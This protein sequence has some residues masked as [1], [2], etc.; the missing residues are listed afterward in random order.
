MK[1]CLVLLV[2][3]LA[4]IPSP[5]FAQLVN[6]GSI[7]VNSSANPGEVG[8]PVTFTVTVTGVIRLPLPIITPTGTVVFKDNGVAIGNGTLDSNGQATLT[9]SSLSVGSHP[10]T[11]TYNGDVVYNPATSSALSQSIV[12]GA[13]TT[14]VVSS[15]NPS[16]FGSNVTFTATVSGAP[17]G[18]TPT[19]TVTFEDGATVI[20]S[21]SL[22]GSGQAAFSTSALSGGS[23]SITAVYGGD[24]NFAGSTSPTL[25]QTVN[26]TSSSTSVAASSNP[27]TFGSSV[28]F[29]ATVS[30]S[31]GTPSGTVT[32][33]D[34][35]STLGTGTLSGGQATL[36][37]ASETVGSHSITAV[38]G[39][40][41]NFA[42]STSS[43]LTFVVN[44]AASSTQVTSSLNPSAVGG[45]VTFTATVTVPN[46]TATGT[47][48][49]KDGGSTIGSGSLAGN[50]TATVTTS[51]LAL[52]SHSITAVYGGDG[53]FVGSTSSIL[54]QMV[55]VD[56]STTSLS[57]SINP[58][59]FGT[60]VTFTAIVTGVGPTPTG[61]VT[62]KNG[63]STM[64]SSNLDGSGQATFTTSV[65][66]A[67]SHAISAVY[68]GDTT[69]GASISPTVTQTV[70]QNPT[71]TALTAA[72][73]PTSP[74]TSVTLTAV[75]T[76]AGG[77][78]TGTVTFDDG[79]T[80]LG[81]V[82]LNGSG[83]AV[84]T[85][86][87][88]SGG[89]HTLSATYNGD[90]NFTAS[91]SPTVALVENPNATSTSVAAT[92]NPA[93]VGTTISLTATV[94]AS[95]TPTGNV[96]FRDGAATIGTAALNGSAQ[97]SLAVA[98]LASGTHSITA[99]YGGDVNFTGSTS[100]AISVAI[101]QRTVTVSLSSSLNP[102]IAG[103]PVTFAATVTSSSGTPSG[104][105]SFRDGATVLAT[106]NLASGAT[107]L[108]TSSLVSGTHSITA[109]YNGD[110]NYA[111]ATSAAL[112]QSVNLPADSLKLRA[113]QIAA[114][115]IA[116]QNS[117]AAVASA[118]HSAVSEGFADDGGLLVPSGSGVRFNSAGSS[119]ERNAS[120]AERPRWVL[121]ADMLYSGLNTD[122]P[123]QDMTGQQ[124][125]GL[126]GM[127]FRATPDFLV[128][129]LGGYENFDYV[130][131][132]LNGRFQG[133][134][135]T[136]GSYLGW[137]PLSGLRFEAGLAYSA[138]NLDG[139][140]GSASGSFPG[141][142][143]L[144]TT[145]LTGN[146]K[147]TQ[148]LEFEPS[149]QVFALLEK[150]QGY[151]D[152]LGTAQSDR[153]FSTGRASV[154]TKWLYRSQWGDLS[155]V[156][157]F[158]VYGDYYFSKDDATAALS[159]PSLDG[160]SLRATSGL[161][162]AMASGAQFTVGG[163]LGGIG[164]GS[165]DIWSARARVAVPF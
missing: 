165:F 16:Q 160:A 100:P 45:A 43:P 59:N 30:G 108:T 94:A 66:V 146:Y 67:G 61:T 114:T 85:V 150:E 103:Q 64:G 115:R 60:A 69:Y 41:G 134:G 141:Y 117:G 151:T 148:H 15:S 26:P 143:M 133:G 86:G 87:T 101:Q 89:T 159:V 90:S 96:T 44:Q 120:A 98:T 78:P 49:F 84:L 25:T 33:K 6:V 37:T 110:A 38:Y 12:Q 164:S 74:G 107:A 154:G 62:F 13:T 76:G 53:N 140:A 24:G 95:G 128:G 149:M 121:W 54:T 102:S 162:V 91:L 97:A 39:G 138:L 136:T 132:P 123:N 14:T 111:A 156:P 68:S 3:A 112:T 34:G 72:P 29:T 2:L 17:S 130:S 51:T 122:R 137:Q 119:G 113:L 58:S 28:T 48:T 77:T 19:G 124:W 21:G 20:G 161:T 145:G 155:V 152:S 106:T 88:L 8:T 40:D 135:W 70:G 52:G 163:E 109:A 93:A 36:T 75:V 65:L 50:G 126:A 104:T 129:M 18:L 144:A 11:V 79:A 127:T 5:A 125:N 80:A 55:N 35:G 71:V 7:T 9:T 147:I 23:H 83:H 82:A 139:V 153:T 56:S 4:A 27:A 46:G 92:P 142:R 1:G 105:V 32:F 73:N 118:I 116:A 22:N 42:T 157:Y 47:V 131:Q 31:G 99:V 10:I 63:G 57:S 81:T 158:G